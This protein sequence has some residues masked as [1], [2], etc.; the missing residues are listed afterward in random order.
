MHSLGSLCRRWSIL[1]LTI[2]ALVSGGCLTDGSALFKVQAD[3]IESVEKQLADS[4]AAR[5]KLVQDQSE[6][7]EK[8]IRDA[9]DA[10]MKRAENAAN[11]IY[12]AR[13]ANA[14]NPQK[15]RET[16]LVDHF[17]ELA[18]VASPR[19]PNGAYVAN[20]TQELPKLEDP[21]L[22]D[23]ELVKRL[24]T[25]FEAIIKDNLTS[26]AKQKAI[27]D[28]TVEQRQQLNQID[29][30][31]GSDTKQVVDAHRSLTSKL[32]ESLRKA[33]D[34]GKLYQQLVWLFGGCAALSLLAAG[35]CA[36][37]GNP[38]MAMYAGMASGAFVACTFLTIWLDEN[39][40]V[41]WVVFGGGLALGLGTLILRY[42]WGVR[43]TQLRLIAGSR[44]EIRRLLNRKGKTLE[45]LGFPHEATLNDLDVHDLEAVQDQLVK[46]HDA[47]V[48]VVPAG[49]GQGGGGADPA[50][51]AAVSN[52]RF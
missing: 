52:G 40:W 38:R 42:G 5:T 27:D 49:G 11:N 10:D 7:R 4:Q 25:E 15:N 13:K 33:N 16:L 46:M 29:S 12:A 2:L 36:Y 51:S 50:K 17:A 43:D 47:H 31:I 3:R 14:D 23:E 26:V 8:A 35:V 1:P 34:T 21:K 48:V 30:K 22:S 18:L 28:L 44:D 45:M 19:S 32:V 20:L 24:H 37:L 41:V 39:R 6:Q 9:Y